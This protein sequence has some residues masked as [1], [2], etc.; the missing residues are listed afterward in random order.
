MTKNVSVATLVQAG[1]EAVE[2]NGLAGLTM[3]DVAQ[4]LG[5]KAPAIY[6]HVKSRQDLVDEM[7]TE[8]WR[9]VQ[10][11]VV[12]QAAGASPVDGLVILARAVRKEALFRRDGARVMAGTYL[13]DDT[14]LREQQG[15]LHDLS[16]TNAEALIT[17]YTLVYSFVIGY[18]IEEQARLAAPELYDQAVRAA[19]VGDA[20]PAL[21][22]VA[23]ATGDQRF[24]QLLAMI[25]TTARRDVLPEPGPGR[26]ASRGRSR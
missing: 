1:F 24:E 11:R 17:A 9:L 3:R 2:E 7:A 23:L 10:R 4:R 26:P 5:V 22:A 6:W 16:P 19:R 20:D 12:E 18:V 21:S 25:I 8:M 15:A 13:T 14:L